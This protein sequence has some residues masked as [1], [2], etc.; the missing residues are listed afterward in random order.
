MAHPPRAISPSRINLPLADAPGS[1]T[2]PANPINSPNINPEQWL[3]A[4]MRSP[5]A[6]LS[7]RIEAALRLI[8]LFPEVYLYGRDSGVTYKITNWEQ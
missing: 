7:H 8:D 5:T 6:L 3:L 2:D 4:L 1:L